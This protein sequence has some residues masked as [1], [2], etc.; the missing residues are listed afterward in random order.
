MVSN[1]PYCSYFLFCRGFFGNSTILGCFKN[2]CLKKKSQVFLDFKWVN[3]SCLIFFGVLLLCNGE[4]NGILTD[5]A[6]PLF[7]RGLY[8]FFSIVGVLIYV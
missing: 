5:G 8:G 7:Q 6:L 4:S 2:T 3:D 1:T